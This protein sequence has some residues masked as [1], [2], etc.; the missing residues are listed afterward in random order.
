MTD[1]YDNESYIEKCRACG[2]ENRFEK[3]RELNE[4]QYLDIGDGYIDIDSDDTDVVG[5]W[6]YACLVCANESDDLEDLLEEI[7]EDDDEF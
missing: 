1:T 2:A 5:E 4:R 7:E 6:K 3:F